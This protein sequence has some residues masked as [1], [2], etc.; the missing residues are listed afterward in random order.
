M[1]IGFFEIESKKMKKILKFFLNFLLP[2]TCPICH[3]RIESNGLC[4]KCF[5]GLEF[6]GTQKCSICGKPLDAIIPKMAVC[7]ACLKNPPYF[8]QAEAVF[9]YNDT[10][11]KLILAFKHV[12]HVDLN[13][14]FIKWMEQNSGKLIQK[15]DLIIPVPLHWRRLLKRKYNQSALIAQGLAKNFGKIY[16]PLTLIRRKPTKSQGH[17][18]PK[19]R[20]KNIKNAFY[21]KNSNKIKD[22]TILL[23]D[24]VFTTGATVNE[25]AKVLLQAGAKSVDVLTIVRVVRE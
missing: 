22:K 23:I 9:K 12:D 11:K 10:S 4:P 20:Q 15:N 17:L 3:Q 7:G 21:V 19:E 5:S 24:D 13:N 16:D 1:N 6:I 2:P 8:R 18:S 25:C 14:L